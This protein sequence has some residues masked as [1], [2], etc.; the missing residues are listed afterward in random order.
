MNE[1]QA[2]RGEGLARLSALANRFGAEGQI[3]LFKLA[4]AAIY[5]R[6]QRAGWERRP[7]VT[8][9][10]MNTELGAAIAD[11]EAAGVPSHFVAALERSRQAMADGQLPLIHEAPDVYVCRTCG[12]IALRQPPE[13]CPDCGA[14]PRRFRRFFSTFNLEAPDPLETLDM[15]AEAPNVVE[16]LV[17]GLSEEAMARPPEGGG[18]SLY[19]L[20]KH[21]NDAQGVLAGRLELML[22]QDKPKLTSQAVFTWAQAQ[23]ERPPAAGEI[24]AGYRRTR[25]AVIECLEGLTLRD[26]WRTGQHEEFGTVTILHQASYFAAHEHYH[27]PEIEAL[28]RQIS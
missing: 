22:N 1:G 23:D 26:W 13:R 16:A 15:L 20:V 4:D 5:A 10:A 24:L 19:N 27:F 25:E 17:A 21:L 8:A 7:R 3:N 11:L 6:I 9:E 12:H 28:R 2:S 18:W 14:W